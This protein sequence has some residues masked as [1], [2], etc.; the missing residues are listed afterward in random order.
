MCEPER[1]AGST[2]IVIKFISALRDRAGVSEERLAL[3]KG[4]T[5]KSVSVHLAQRYGLHVPAMDS[6][7]TLNGHGWLQAAQGL[8]MLL[9]D[10]DVIH[11]FPP[12]S[13]G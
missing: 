1:G 10:G 11:L 7:A 5:L 12:I 13:G 2:T 8:D 6:M 9:Q 4:A 3:P